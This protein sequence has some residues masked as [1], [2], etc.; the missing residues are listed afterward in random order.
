MKT[1]HFPENIY[2]K[3]LKDVEDRHVLTAWGESGHHAIRGSYNVGGGAA[4]VCYE[5]GC[6]AAVGF[7]RM[8]SNG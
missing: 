4:F 8:Y 2:G 1:Q 5:H 3:M 7:E 6:H